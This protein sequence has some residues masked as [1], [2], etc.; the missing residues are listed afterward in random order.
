DHLVAFVDQRVAQVRA[1]E[2]GAA[3]DQ[4]T[5]WLFGKHYMQPQRL[6]SNTRL[7][8]ITTRSITTRSINTWLYLINARSITTHWFGPRLHSVTTRMNCLASVVA[9]SDAALDVGALFV[10]VPGHD[11]QVRHWIVVVIGVM[12]EDTQRVFKCLAAAVGHVAVQGPGG[13]RV[14]ETGPHGADRNLVGMV[15][16]HAPVEG[17]QVVLAVVAA[18]AGPAVFSRLHPG[19]KTD[20][21]SVA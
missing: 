3:G 1:H 21:E 4:H 18:V 17:F 8:S 12:A 9:M 16:L 6:H 19:I 20:R 14:V 2:P 11:E 7:S 10:V 13:V 5:Q 15:L